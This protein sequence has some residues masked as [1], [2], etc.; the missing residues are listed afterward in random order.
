VVA[1]FA[2]DAFDAFAFDDFAFD[3]FAFDDFARDDFAFAFD[4]DFDFGATTFTAAPYMA[5]TSTKVPLRH[6]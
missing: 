3:D 2:F 6:H 1:L 4:F 5:V